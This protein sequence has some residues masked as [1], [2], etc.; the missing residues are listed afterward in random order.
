MAAA[1]VVAVKLPGVVTVQDVSLEHKSQVRGSQSHIT[2]AQVTSIEHDSYKIET[3]RTPLHLVTFVCSPGVSF[4]KRMQSVLFDLLRH[5][6]F[7]I[8]SDGCRFQI[9]GFKSVTALDFRRCT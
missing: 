9:P 2:P 1:P 5:R 7:W 8:S 4:V 6:L 3:M